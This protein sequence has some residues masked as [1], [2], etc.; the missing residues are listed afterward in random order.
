MTKTIP[1]ITDEIVERFYEAYQDNGYPMF[2]SVEPRIRRALTA[3]LTTEPEIEVTEAMER[4]GLSAYYNTHENHYQPRY[5][6]HDNMARAYR[7]MVKAAPSGAKSAPQGV[8]AGAPEKATGGG[9]WAHIGEWF[10]HSRET[11]NPEL[12]FAASLRKHRR[13]TDPK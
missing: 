6:A 4:A 2:S 8:S 3:A 7:A 11:D 5:S 1:E 10:T 9:V 12:H 13:S